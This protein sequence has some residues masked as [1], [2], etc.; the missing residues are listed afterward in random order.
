[1]STTIERN[2]VLTAE[3]RAN[4]VRAWDK[5]VAAFEG[6]S[7]EVGLN[8]VEDC[9]AFVEGVRQEM[10]EERLAARLAKKTFGGE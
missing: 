5:L 10:Y 2:C 7:D 6:F 3:D 4:N 1:M 8:S 9:D